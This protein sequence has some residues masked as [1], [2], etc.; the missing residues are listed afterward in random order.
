MSRRF[1][2]IP[3]GQ[4]DNSRES[5]TFLPEFLSSFADRSRAIWLI[6]KSEIRR[7]HWCTRRWAQDRLRVCSNPQ[8]AFENMLT[9]EMRRDSYIARTAKECGFTVIEPG[10]NIAEIVR[11]AEIQFGLKTKCQ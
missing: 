6:A 2:Y 4:H 5:V 1:A 11:F 9:M 3:S 10:P 7:A 8:R